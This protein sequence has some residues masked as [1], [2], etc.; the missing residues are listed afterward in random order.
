M[1]SES[2]RVRSDSAPPPAGGGQLKLSRSAR[3]PQHW[4]VCGRLRLSHTVNLN[5]ER[6]SAGRVL[7]VPQLSESPVQIG[8]KESARSLYVCDSKMAS[9]PLPLPKDNFFE[10][11]KPPQPFFFSCKVSRSRNLSLDREILTHNLSR[12]SRYNKPV[13]QLFFNQ[14]E[15]VGCNT[16]PRIFR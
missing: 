16:L 13:Q 7:S 3:G 6:V 2:R 5:L 1:T 14:E 12:T 8:T 11:D 4:T 15:I 10:I 9:F